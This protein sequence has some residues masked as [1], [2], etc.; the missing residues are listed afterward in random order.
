[1]CLCV[2]LHKHIIQEY[3][4]MK[5]KVQAVLDILEQN[6]KQLLQNYDRKQKVTT[7]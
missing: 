3:T 1:M 2:F 6:I 4:D 7:A 5:V